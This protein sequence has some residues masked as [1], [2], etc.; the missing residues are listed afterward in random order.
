MSNRDTRY[1]DAISLSEERGEAPHL[2]SLTTDRSGSSEGSLIKNVL[3][4]KL[5]D[6]KADDWR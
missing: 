1:L 4:L 5:A 2:L 6:E 3:S